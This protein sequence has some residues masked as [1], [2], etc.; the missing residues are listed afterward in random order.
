MIKYFNVSSNYRFYHEGITEK[1]IQLF[2][3]FIAANIPFYILM[4]S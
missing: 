2:F 4:I 1:E 3:L